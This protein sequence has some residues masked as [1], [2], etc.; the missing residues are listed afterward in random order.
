[1]ESKISELSGLPYINLEDGMVIMETSKYH[2]GRHG[3][4]LVLLNGELATVIWENGTSVELS[5]NTEWVIFKCTRR[6][7]PEQLLIEKLK[8]A[9]KM[10]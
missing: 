5:P 2:H 1:M 8:H 6:L 7:T 9:D 4:G 10:R 3:Y